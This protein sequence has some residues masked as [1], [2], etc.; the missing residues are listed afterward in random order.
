M[1]SV[2]SEKA[3]QFYPSVIRC[4]KKH[5]PLVFCFLVVTGHHVITCHKSSIPMSC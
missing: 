2:K 3:F 5:T 4:E 1:L